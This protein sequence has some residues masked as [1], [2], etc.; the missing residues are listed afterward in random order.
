MCMR[1]QTYVDVG[2]VHGYREAMTMLGVAY[3]RV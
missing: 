3:D 1:G 2:T